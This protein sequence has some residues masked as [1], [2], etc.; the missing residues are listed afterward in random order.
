MLDENAIDEELG[1][2]RGEIEPA[3]N[4]LIP[5][6]HGDLK[7]LA[8]AQRR[9]FDA[10]LTLSTTAVV[11]ELYL[12]LL[13]AS[14]LRVESREHFFA[15]A[16][17][18]IRQILTDHARRVVNRKQVAVEDLEGLGFSAVDAGP[19]LEIDEALTQLQRINPRLV[20]VVNC[21]FF[22]GYSEEETATILGV[23]DRTV[24]RDWERAR[25]W[26]GA[27]LKA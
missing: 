2:L 3:L 26:L 5:A 18:A 17:L 24:R 8:A 21:R 16:A 27:A 6:L 19:L 23:S 25:A 9:R 7:R 13:N 12:K 22:G 11:N 1:R 20:S 15:L 14:S 4:R 10:S